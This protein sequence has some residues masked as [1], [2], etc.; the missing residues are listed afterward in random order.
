MYELGCCRC[1]LSQ[2]D[3]FR[4]ESN[5]P[6][7]AEDI[8]KQTGGTETGKRE[9]TQ[10]SAVRTGGARGD[11]GAVGEAKGGNTGAGL[12]QEGVGVAVV[13]ADELDELQFSRKGAPEGPLGVLHC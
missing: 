3:I 12:D 10:R 8:V 9:W 11:T 4:K 1:A 6:L 13:A 5:H 2:D 7:K